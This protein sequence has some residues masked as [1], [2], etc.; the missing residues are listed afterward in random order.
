MGMMYITSLVLSMHHHFEKSFLPFNLIVKDSKRCLL[1]KTAR[2]VEWRRG[3][4]NPRP[5]M[6]QDKLLHA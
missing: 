2:R 3:D 5:V 1:A 4:S 6:L